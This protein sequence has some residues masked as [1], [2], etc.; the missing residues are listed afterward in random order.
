MHGP[1]CACGT[2]AVGLC[3]ECSRPIC[4][5]HSGMWEGVRLCGDHYHKKRTERDGQLQREQQARNAAIQE[6]QA[7][8][9]QEQYRAKAERQAKLVDAW[10]QIP[11]LLA[12][13][14]ASRVPREKVDVT[15]RGKW[16][17]REGWLLFV[18]SREG[19]MGYSMEPYHVTTEGDFITRRFPAA[20]VRVKNP[21]AG[22][23]MM[24]GDGPA[25]WCPP[26]DWTMIADR[27][28]EL[29]SGG[30]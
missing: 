12:Q 29:L 17:Q 3:K 25:E 5:I 7:I 6:R 16:R 19:F 9:Q 11:G 13:L 28:R 26:F 18:D 14:R 27:L 24:G 1:I 4:G 22:A 30:G 8:E 10:N 23:R 20:A 21:E 15:V 2:F